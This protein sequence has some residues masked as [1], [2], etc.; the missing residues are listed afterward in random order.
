M[1]RLPAR[2]AEGAALN[3][4]RFPAGPIERAPAGALK[5][6]LILSPAFQGKALLKEGGYALSLL[7]PFI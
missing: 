5:K 2:R 1:R 4:R 6:E 3:A 7:R